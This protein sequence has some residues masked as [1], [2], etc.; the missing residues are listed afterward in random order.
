M[1]PVWQKV[2]GKLPALQYDKL[3]GVGTTNV[4]WNLILHKAFST[5]FK[6][7]VASPLCYCTTE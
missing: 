7:S 6:A 1:T 2:T 3:L 4:L 5:L